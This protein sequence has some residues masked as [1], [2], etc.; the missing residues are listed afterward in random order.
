MVC[1]FGEQV[2]QR[3]C[4]FCLAY[5]SQIVPLGEVSGHVALW[6]GPPGEELKPPNKSHVL[7]LGS[8]LIT[9]ACMSP[10][11]QADSS[12]MIVPEPEGSK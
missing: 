11:Q 4:G 7:E 2:I 10:H 5:A 1:N 6:R 8:F 12:L 3:R 9:A